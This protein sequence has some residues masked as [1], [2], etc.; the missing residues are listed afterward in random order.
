MT[1]LEYEQF[2]QF[3]YDVLYEKTTIDDYEVVLNSL[4]IPIVSKNSEYWTLK[5]G[6]HNIDCSCCGNNLVFYIEERSFYCFS[7]CHSSY[8]LLS[9]TK[10]RFETIGENKTTTQSLK[11]ICKCLDIP[12]NFKE[13][14]KRG[15][16]HILNWK[17]QLLK[18]TKDGRK[19]NTEKKKYDKKILSYFD[20][21]YYDDWLNEGL[22]EE[23]LDKFGIKWYN[24]EQQI[25]I[26][27]FDRNANLVG[28]RVRNIEP[29]KAERLG[30]YRPLEMLNGTVYKFPTNDYFY[31]E[32]LNSDY[33]RKIKKC[34]LVESEKAVIK[35]ETFFGRKNF[36]LGLMGHSIGQEQINYL[37]ELGVKDIYL[38]LDW[39]YHDINDDEYDAYVEGV[40]KLYFKMKPYFSRIFVIVNPNE[41]NDWYKCNIFDLPKDMF[42]DIWDKRELIIDGE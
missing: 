7:E 8:N 26:P 35:S 5:S 11:Y 30:K 38:C 42:V 41:H 22:S 34:C 14:V 4:D 10:K 12:F 24:S 15:N 2:K 1:D 29:T 18:Y 37:V 32:N 17:Q 13:D 21:A 33:I 28:I 40:N 25:V 6:C 27:C 23:A 19:Y 39:D 36:C 31:G 16:G 20:N 3:I 9:L